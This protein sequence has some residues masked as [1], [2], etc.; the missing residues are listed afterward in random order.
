MFICNSYANNNK[1]TCMPAKSADTV[2]RCHGNMPAEDN[3]EIMW[4]LTCWDAVA[5]IID[6]GVV[7]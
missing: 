1:K 2:L 6:A 3:E 5:G 7:Q 4:S